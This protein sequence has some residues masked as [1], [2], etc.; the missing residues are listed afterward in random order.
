MPQ[1]E[2]SLLKALLDTNEC[3]FDFLDRLTAVTHAH[4]DFELLTD[5]KHM[6]FDFEH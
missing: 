1:V 2:K 6:L 5:Q 4:F 3:R